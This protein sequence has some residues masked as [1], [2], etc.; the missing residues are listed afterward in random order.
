MRFSKQDDGFG[1]KN[2]SK[3]LKLSQ[4]NNQALKKLS[5]MYN[6]SE[7]DI[8]NEILFLEKK[9]LDILDKVE[10]IVEK[11]KV[12]YIKTK[13]DQGKFIGYYPETMKN[14]MGE[15]IKDH[16]Q[17]PVV[18]NRVAYE[19]I[20]I[21]IREAII[22]PYK[23]LVEFRKSINVYENFNSP[24]LYNNFFNGN[25]NITE[26]KELLNIFEELDINVYTISIDAINY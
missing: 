24:L 18:V 1:K 17:N 3:Q 23:Y 25:W 10:E 16:W 6:T 9:K 13:P 8:I 22:P 12:C 21:I 15:T 5:D 11:N 14:Q 7:S 20:E 4:E 26:F 19:Y 2:V